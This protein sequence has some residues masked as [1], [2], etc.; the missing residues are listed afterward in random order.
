[1]PKKSS[2]ARG[3]KSKKRAIAG[4]SSDEEGSGLFGIEET[5]KDEAEK[6]GDEAK[7]EKQEEVKAAEEDAAED[8]DDI[9]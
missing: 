8:S 9:W 3:S 5:K 1:M 6:A 7:V 4:T 2:K